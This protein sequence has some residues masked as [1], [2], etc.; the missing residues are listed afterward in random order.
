MAAAPPVQL[1]GQVQKAFGGQDLPEVEK[2]L[3][4]VAGSNDVFKVE[5]GELFGS[6]SETQKKV[7][8]VKTFKHLAT[9]K[10]VNDP[11]GTQKKRE[12]VLNGYRGFAEKKGI[13]WR[14]ESKKFE[15]RGM[16]T[17]NAEYEAVLDTTLAIPDY[18]VRHGQGT[19]HSYQGGN[20]NWEAA[21]DAPSAYLLVHLHHYTDRTPQQCFDALHKELDD[22]AICALNGLVPKTCVDIGCAVGTSTFSTRKSLDEAGFSEAKLT[23]LDLSAHFIA[24]A[25]HRLNSGDMTQFSA[26]PLEFK[27]G[28]G[29]QLAKAGFADGSCQMV[30]ASEVTHEMPMHVSRMLL[31]EVSRVL[32]P[33]GVF[34]YMDLN[35]HQI[36]RDNPPA[37]LIQRIAMSN[38]PYFDEYLELDMPKAMEEAG[39]TVVTQEWPNHEKYPTAIDCSLRIIIARK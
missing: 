13:E 15:E 9:Q 19:L 30:M 11:D 1:K 3:E 32:Q 27:H 4:D 14:A 28:D 31:A 10:V 16:D 2:I 5:F 38:E 23:G 22:Y 12:G 6:L 34:A 36:L 25:K 29:L 37:N 17:W 39:L 18:Y 26:S 8:V 33:G 20:C 21:F 24:V 35:P 7:A